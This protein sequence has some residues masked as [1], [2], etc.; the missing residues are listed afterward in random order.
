MP[1]GA[2]ILFDEEAE[3]TIRGSWTALADAGIS[4]SMLAPGIRP[5]LSL[6]VCDGSDLPRL[7]TRL[8]SLAEETEGFALGLPSLGV[9]ADTGVLYLAVTPRRALFAL[10]RRVDSVCAAGSRALEDWYRPDG[11]MPHVTLA[12]GLDADGLAAAIRLLAG[13]PRK[14]TARAESLAL[15][16]G[17]GTGWTVHDAW[18]LG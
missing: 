9:F 2:V 8:G 12:F 10:H 16:E 11:W 14:L 17:D 13:A 18:R 4:R 3:A 5:H 7:R 1:L 15:I 6:S